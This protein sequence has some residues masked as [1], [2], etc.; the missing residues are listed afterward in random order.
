MTE[1]ALAL[2]SGHMLEAEGNQGHVKRVQ[3]K[4]PNLVTFAGKKNVFEWGQG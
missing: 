4:G 1:A 2:V 3:P